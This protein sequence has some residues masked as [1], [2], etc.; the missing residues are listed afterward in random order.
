MKNLFF[1]SLIILA[2]CTTSQRIEWTSEINDFEAI[3]AQFAEPSN[4][5]GT[6]PLW[7]W[8]TKVTNDIIDASLKDLKD[9]GFGGVFIHPRPGMI[10]SYLSDDWFALYKHSIAKGK[11]LGLDVW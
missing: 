6:A 5:F 2:A 4:H 8:N 11:E 1:L 9:K 7:V 10:T 3:K